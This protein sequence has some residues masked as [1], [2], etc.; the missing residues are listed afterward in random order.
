MTANWQ[1]RLSGLVLVT[2]FTALA[3]D[4]LGVPLLVKVAV[5][6]FFLAAVSLLAL[7]AVKTIR[8]SEPDMHDPTRTDETK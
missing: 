1:S 4:L 6:T 5:P 7:I 2:L 3:G 8:S